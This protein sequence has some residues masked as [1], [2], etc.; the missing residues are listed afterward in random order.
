M[1]LIKLVKKFKRVWREDGILIAIGRVCHF[2]G[3]VEG[4]KIRRQDIHT[5]KEMKGIVLFINGCCVEHPTRY[6]VIHQMEQLEDS[7]VPCAKV[8]FED[9]ELSMVNNFELFIFYRCE[10]TDE[11]E[12]FIHK[13]KQDGKTVCFDI[14]DLVTD[15]KYTDQVPFVQELSPENKRIFDTSVMLTGKTLSMCDIAIVTTEALAGELGKVVSETYINRNTA[16]KE[17]VVCAEHAYQERKKGTDK[18]LLGYFS[19]SLTHNKDFEII[20]AAIM[21]MME[22][23]PQVEL[24]LVGELDASD[25]LM[26]HGARIKVM[27]ATDW[28]ILPNM[29]AQVDIN[30]APLENTLF[31][32]AKSELKW[33]EAALVRVPTIASKVGAYEIMIDNEKTGV[34]CDNNYDSWSD[35]LSMLIENPI[36]REKIGK[37]AYLFA[38]EHCI[39]TATAAKY[40]KF[41]LDNI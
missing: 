3:N 21:H 25:E 27:K 13:A 40:R 33:L 26:Q 28:R 39:T 16:S 19:G 20:H 35:N 36:M 15:T 7:G 29:I 22:K 9:I 4:R 38:M 17:M 11:V 12:K 5:A 14:D 41:I 34:L 8:Y 24:L 31:N 2:A 32:Q 30:L 1:K 23:Y 37:A 6:R 18:V 10:W